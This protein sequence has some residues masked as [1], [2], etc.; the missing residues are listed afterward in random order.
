MPYINK[1]PT[2]DIDTFPGAVFE[3]VGD[4]PI[5]QCEETQI[6]DAGPVWTISQNTIV[7]AAAGVDINLI[8]KI[9]TVANSASDNGDWTIIAQVDNTLTLNHTWIGAAAGADI[10]IHD[11]GQAY[12]T[13]NSQSFA[14]FIH[15]LGY[16][17]TIKGGKLYT[18]CPNLTLADACTNTW[19]PGE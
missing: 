3:Q 17:Y 12:L 13:R 10:V 18:D 7:F 5:A 9:I 11:T 15:D 4:V 8:G 2:P 1:I 16:A 14:Q 6:V 19:N